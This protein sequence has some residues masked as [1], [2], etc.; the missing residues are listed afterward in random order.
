VAGGTPSSDIEE[1]WNGE[2]NWVTLVDL[3]AEWEIV[4]L[5]TIANLIGGGTPSR[6]VDKY[7]D[8]GDIDW[9][10]CSDFTSNSMY[11]PDSIGKITPEGL[12]NSSS[13]LIKEDTLILVTRVSLGK[14]AFT[15]KP[16]AINQDLTACEL[17][18]SQGITFLY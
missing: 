12:K 8:N 14:L 6:Q 15:R 11:L 5:G 17:I 1:Y 7:W 2:I 9:V 4:E 10:S 16:T 3:P 18:L 13:N